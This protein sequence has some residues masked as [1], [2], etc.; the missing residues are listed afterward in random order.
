LGVLG[1]FVREVE[2]AV[3]GGDEVNRVVALRK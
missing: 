2:D 1:S 3:S